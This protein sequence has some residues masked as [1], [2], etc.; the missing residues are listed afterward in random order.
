MNDSTPSQPDMLVAPHPVT[1][2]PLKLHLGCGMKYLPGF[3][4]V[5]ILPAPHIDH[6]GPVDRLPMFADNSVDLIYASH[7]LEHFGRYQYRE[8]LAEW[9]RVLRPEGVLRLAVPD[10]AACAKIYYEQ[11]LVDGLSG[12][13]GLICGGQRNTYDTHY[14]IFDEPFLSRVLLEIG[15]RKVRRWDWRLTEHAAIDDYS[16]AYL[17]HLD[18]EKGLHMSLNLEA[19]K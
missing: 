4:H 7:V 1:G 14:M 18:K 12:L 17:P 10:F 19:V 15:F 9:F 5:D 3:F 16:Q 6:V 11:G 2:R 13:I 8:V